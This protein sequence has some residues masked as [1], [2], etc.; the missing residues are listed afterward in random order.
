MKATQTQFSFFCQNDSMMNWV[1]MESEFKVQKNTRVS[2]RTQWISQRTQC[3]LQAHVFSL[4]SLWF[5]VSFVLPLAKSLRNLNMPST[6][7]SHIDYNPENQTLT[8]KFVSGSTYEYLKVPEETYR[9]FMQYRE[10]GVYLNQH[11]K[12]NFEYKKV[13]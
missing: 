4:C 13:N 7:I 5:I 10:K 11:I 2:Q 1:V 6:V 12:K 9:A 3:L 8:I